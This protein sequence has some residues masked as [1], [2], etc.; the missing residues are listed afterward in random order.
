MYE[1]PFD[2]VYSYVKVADFWI[3]CSRSEW[4]GFTCYEFSKLLEKNLFSFTGAI[5]EIS[6]W[7][8]VFFKVDS[9]K[10]FVSG[11]KKLHKDKIDYYLFDKNLSEQKM[12]NSYKKIY[13][14]L[15]NN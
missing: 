10:S 6:F 2:K 12:V 4:F 9:D 14:D 11:F 7:K 5:P 15:V 13:Q 1:I 8:I 3:V